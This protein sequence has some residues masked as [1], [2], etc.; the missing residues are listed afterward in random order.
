MEEMLPLIW[1]RMILQL[2]LAIHKLQWRCC[3]RLEASRKEPLRF[4]WI[5]YLFIY[6]I[7]PVAVG[8]VWTCDRDRFFKKEKRTTVVVD[9]YIFLTGVLSGICSSLDVYYLY[10]ISCF[11]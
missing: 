3:Q 8:W 4:R 7:R 5:K 2:Q 9:E 6:S 10:N 1:S 11:R